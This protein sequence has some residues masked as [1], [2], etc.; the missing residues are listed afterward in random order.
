MMFTVS[1]VGPTI[2][3]LRILLVTS[4]SWSPQRIQTIRF[5]DFICIITP[6]KLKV[7]IFSIP[8]FFFFFPFLCWIDYKKKLSKINVIIYLNGVQTKGCSHTFMCKSWK[9]GKFLGCMP[10]T[11]VCGIERLIW[12]RG[13]PFQ[14][15]IK[16]SRLL[17]VY[18]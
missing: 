1:K 7:S 18:G 4:L 13:R 11:K 6:L 16:L 5:C 12:I 17:K 14:N 15:F 10:I 9:R 8:S 2:P 3:R